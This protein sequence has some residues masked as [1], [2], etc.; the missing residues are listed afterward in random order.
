MVVREAAASIGFGESNR[1]ISIYAT[2]HDEREEGAW[3]T[4]REDIQMKK[5]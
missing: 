1:G 4:T 5:G 2:T 3:S